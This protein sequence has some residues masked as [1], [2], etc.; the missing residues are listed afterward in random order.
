MKKLYALALA[1]FGALYSCKKEPASFKVTTKAVNEAVYASGEIM[2]VQYEVIKATSNEHILKILVAQGEEV[3]KGQV[4][5]VLGQ[6]SQN[7]QLDILGKQLRLAR[8]NASD[9]S[10]R[11]RELRQRAALA[12]EQYDHDLAESQ[13]YQELALE[14]AVPAQEAGNRAMKAQTS[15]TEYKNLQYEYEALL[16]DQRE[17]VLSVGRQLAELRQHRE[18]NVLT[19]SIGGKV[20]SIY[21]TEGSTAEAG[22]P[23]LLTGTDG[24]FKLELLVDERDIARVKLGQ[25][26]FFETDAFEGKQ[27][28]AT[29]SKIVPVVQKE[30]RS[31]KVEATVTDTGSFFPQSSVEANILIRRQGNALV[32]P[33]TFLQPGDSVWSAGANDKVVKRK[34]NVGVRSGQWTEIKGGLKAGD[35]VYEKAP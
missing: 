3:Q 15:L 1:S 14:K 23:I 35:L 13:K 11:G 26:V 10:A 19:S 9:S 27:F 33:S 20:F 6:P 21:H 30:N 17:K 34:L 12:R 7:A 29:V 24:R 2:P 4:L 16:A 31:F 32:I 25:S 5:A 22:D 18:T 8:Q 28:N